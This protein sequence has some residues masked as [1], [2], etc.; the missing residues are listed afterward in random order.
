M[1]L[2]AHRGNYR[3]KN[4]DRENH[5]DY[6]REALDAGYH[7]EIDVWW[8]KDQFWLGHDRPQ[9]PISQESSSSLILPWRK[10]WCHAK[11][12]EAVEHLQRMSMTHW[13]WH[14]TDTL[15]RTSL[16]FLW[17]FPGVF[18]IDSIVNQPADIAILQGLGMNFA[19]ICAD[20]FSELEVEE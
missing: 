1:Y 10:V 3:G 18:L 13:F 4:P 5:P 20:D 11:N 9:Y 2:I 8:H 6:I 16:G 19:G 12:I 17:T 14:E 7:V 15:T